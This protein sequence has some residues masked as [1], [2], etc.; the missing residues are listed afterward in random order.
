MLPRTP[1]ILIR[2][3][4]SPFPPWIANVRVL[5]TARAAS[6]PGKGAP[7]ES[8]SAD[9]ARPARGGA[10]GL[11]AARDWA[12]VADMGEPLRADAIVLLGCRIGAAGRPTLPA[13]R[14]AATAA[15]AYRLG[16]AGAIVV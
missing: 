13:Q 15:R 2:I 8:F 7:R 10:A 16:V 3:P 5:V 1:H 12:M 6:L 11:A 9:A 14:R 4:P